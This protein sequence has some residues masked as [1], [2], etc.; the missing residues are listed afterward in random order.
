[1][2]LRD[3]YETT[4]DRRAAHRNGTAFSAAARIAAH[5]SKYSGVVSP[6]ARIAG[7]LTFHP[8]IR[9]RPQRGFLLCCSTVW[10]VCYIPPTKSLAWVHD[11]QMHNSRRALELL[12]P[13]PRRLQRD[14]NAR[15]RLL[16]RH[17]VIK[18]GLATVQTGWF[19]FGGYRERGVHI[20]E[21]GRR[22]KH[23]TISIDIFNDKGGLIDPQRAAQCAPERFAF[24][25]RP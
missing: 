3:R 7:H 15:T 2:T 14:D 19:V 10:P 18:S 20:T 16:Y 11:L 9:F 23:V 25:D 24:T 17:D 13:V 12:A 8:L 21:A 4:N 22:R 6:Q 5:Q 1:M